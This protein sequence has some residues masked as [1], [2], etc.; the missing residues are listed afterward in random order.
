MFKFE[1]FGN[2]Q[3]G[4]QASLG[5]NNNYISFQSHAHSLGCA[6][7]SFHWGKVHRRLQE[8]VVMGVTNRYNI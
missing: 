8:V 2:E 6:A 1:N 5:A 7:P 4:I 3:S